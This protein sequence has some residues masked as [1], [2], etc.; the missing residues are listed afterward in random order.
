MKKNLGTFLGL[1]SWGVG[2]ALLALCAFTPLSRA[3]VIVDNTARPLIGSDGNVPTAQVFTMPTSGA[4]TY[5]ISSLT[6][7]LGAGSSGTA[8]V[9]VYNATSGNPPSLGYNG[10]GNALYDL[11]SVNGA[12][13]V[14]NLTSPSSDILSLSGTYAIVLAGSGTISWDYTT[15]AGNSNVGATGTLGGSYDW[16][17]T[18]WGINSGQFFQMDLNATPVPEVP[19]TGAV[20]GLGTLA[21]ALGTA[22]RRKIWAAV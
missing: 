4:A 1:S 7:S 21:I 13:G 11:G 15:T 12:T 10:G 5:T 9:Y 8:E 16:S 6:L 22:L 3:D 17:G 18:T 20:M 14:V 19:M 2:A